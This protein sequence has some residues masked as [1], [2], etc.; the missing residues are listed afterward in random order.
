MTSTEIPVRR[1]SLTMRMG[2]VNCP[3]GDNI[4]LNETEKRISKILSYM[5]LFDDD[6]VAIDP[7]R[8]K[9]RFRR[10]SLLFHPDKNSGCFEESTRIFQLLEN[11]YDKLKNLDT[12]DIQRVQRKTFRAKKVSSRKA[13]SRKSPPR[14]A[15]SRKSPPRK[16]SSRK[17]PRRQKQCKED[18]ER[19]PVTGRCR[20]KCK[21][22]EERHPVS[23]RCRSVRSKRSPPRN[24]PKRNCDLNWFTT[25]TN[26]VRNTIISANR[27]KKHAQDCD[28]DT[29]TYRTRARQC[30]QLDLLKRRN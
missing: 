13:S 2:N 7:S 22:H 27:V 21:R 23:G 6:N 5:L 25:K 12:V 14:K 18:E 30:E 26:C 8:I 28:I 1:T 17:S 15:S 4:K 10:I 3:A 11:A 24:S 29:N 20:K 16:A 9:N 19:N